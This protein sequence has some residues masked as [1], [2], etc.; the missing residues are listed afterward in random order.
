LYYFSGKR[1]NSDSFPIIDSTFF[2]FMSQFPARIPHEKRLVFDHRR[3]PKISSIPVVTPV[4]IVSPHFM[5][6]T[7][8][9]L[10]LQNEGWGGDISGFQT[11]NALQNRLPGFEGLVVVD[12]TAPTFLDLNE[13]LHRLKKASFKVLVILSK[14]SPGLFEGL[15]NI[16]IVSANDSKKVFLEAALSANQKSVFRSD[17]VEAGGDEAAFWTLFES[18]S[19][20]QREVFQFLGERMPTSEIAKRMGV[21]SKTVEAHKEHMKRKLNLASC[22]DLVVAAV[23]WKYGIVER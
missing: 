22:Q 21:K 6:R 5:Y 9:R 12:M 18:L 16:S 4:A 2:L 8:L 19:Y 14:Q 20:R 23:L 17:L 11:M 1:V 10:L 13:T 7:G 15:Q 3:Q